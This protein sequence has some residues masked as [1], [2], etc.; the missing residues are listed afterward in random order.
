MEEITIKDIAKL[1]GVGVSTVSRAINNHPDINP[2]TK[3]MILDAINQYGYVPN[4]SARNLKRS[5]GKCIALLAKGISNPFFAMMYGTMEAEI[6]KRKYSFVLHNV[7]SDEDE[8]MVA[9][10]LIKEKRLKGVIFLGGD[11]RHLKK[12]I[13]RLTVPCVLSTVGCEALEIW[14]REYS[15][16]SVDDET[17]VMHAV[18]Y[19]IEN[20]HRRIAIIGADPGDASIG[21][22]RLQ[23]YKKALEK[24]GIP[25]DEELFFQMKDEYVAYSMENGY[26]VG[27]EILAS[28]VDF[29]AVCAI[30]DTLAIGVMRAFTEAGK[31]IPEDYSVIGF[32]GIDLGKYVTPSLT[33]VQQPI[34]TIAKE[35]TS[36]LFD[37]IAGKRKNQWKVFPGELIVRES[38]RRI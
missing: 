3:K 4:N 35:T 23:G 10:R 24:H 38:T 7:E 28:G 26:Q 33:T 27:K 21:Y 30:A 34:E 31:R 16:I 32:D 12:R 6:K 13:P 17:E 19:L 14:D 15:S 20:G 2:D 9:L 36:L 1:C 29:T 5:D 18:E 25:F 22:L 37:L 11:F 8:V